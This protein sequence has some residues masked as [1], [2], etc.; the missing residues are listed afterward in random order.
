MRE[1]STVVIAVLSIFIVAV[2]CYALIGRQEQRLVESRLEVLNGR[3]EGFMMALRD[4]DSLNRA[5]AQDIRK[6]EER[7]VVSEE[8]LSLRINALEHSLHDSRTAESGNINLGSIAIS[9]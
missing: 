8:Q 3:I 5:C 2:F 6:V 4:F 9:K 1:G 7:V